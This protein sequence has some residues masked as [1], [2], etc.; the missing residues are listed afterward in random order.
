MYVSMNVRCG[1]V[2]V[3][4]CM[5]AS[6]YMP[7]MMIDEW[8]GWCIVCNCPVARSTP[9]LA[10]AS[11]LNAALKREPS[12]SDILFVGLHANTV[13]QNVHVRDNTG[14]QKSLPG[15]VLEKHLLVLLFLI[16]FC[17]NSNLRRAI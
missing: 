13:E 12:S 9:I 8:I 10:S 1:C 16:V 11:Q 15:L 17:L 7:V 14:A 6:R 4:V 5:D 3:C 2:I